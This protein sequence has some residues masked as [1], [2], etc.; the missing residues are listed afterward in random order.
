MNEPVIRRLIPPHRVYR[1]FLDSGTR[2]GLL[3][4]AIE[5]KTKFE[6]TKVSQGSESK[7]DSSQR[8]SVRVRHFGP[9]EAILRHRLLNLVPTLINDLR[10]TSFEPCKV[11]LELVAHNDGAFYKRHID[12]A[13]GDARKASHRALSAVYY[14]HTEP[15]AFSGGS[16]R[17]YPFGAQ[18]A[19]GNFIDVQPEQ[20]TLV[21]FPSWA[22]HEVFPVS[23]PSKR[24]VDSRFAVNCWVHRPLSHA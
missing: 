7:H 4:W 15:K 18:E 20:N 9:V 16:L 5:N 23:C 17:L 8:V 12:T 21:A 2:E 19:E 24:F 10:V 11:T 13:I 14:F 1:N 3:A 6:P 22:S